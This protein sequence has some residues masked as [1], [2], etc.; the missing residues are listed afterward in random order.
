MDGEEFKRILLPE[1]T[2]TFHTGS[3]IDEGTTFVVVEWE[4]QTGTMGIMNR[5]G[6]KFKAS[7][8]IVDKLMLGGK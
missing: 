2:V 3:G 1:A 6:F 5:H 7:T 8:E 4:V